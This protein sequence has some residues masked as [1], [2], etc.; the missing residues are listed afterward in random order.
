MY[1]IKNE[2]FGWDS[3]IDGAEHCIVDPPYGAHTHASGATMRGGKSR[4]NDFGFAC[5]DDDLRDAIA[6][7]VGLC[8]S[9]SIIF[10]DWQGLGAWETGLKDEG[11][12]VARVIPWVRWSMPQLSGDR[13]P[14]GWEP[15]ILAWGRGKG[16]KSW[17]GPGNLT[18]FDDQSMR[19]ADK[20]KTQKPLSLMLRIVSYFTAPGSLIVDPCAGRGTTIMA[21]RVLGRSGVGFE[22]DPTEAALAAARLSSEPDKRDAAAICEHNVRAEFERSEKAR[23]AEYTAKVRNSR[24]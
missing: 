17:N 16:K 11:A 4:R 7:Q 10:S 2:K 23:M 15:V 18:H 19:G 5:L 24:A 9:W 1:E 3:V 6:R 8:S 22:C 21:A 12:S 14:Q 20:H 13:P